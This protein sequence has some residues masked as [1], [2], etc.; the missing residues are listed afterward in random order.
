MWTFFEGCSTD[1]Y[2]RAKSHGKLAS[3]VKSKSMTSR[4]SHRKSIF[5][6]GKFFP[7]YPA[8]LRY[9]TP[10]LPI[11]SNAIYEVSNRSSKLIHKVLME[12]GDSSY[13]LSARSQECSSEVKG[14]LLLAKTSTWDNT[15]SSGVEETESVEF[16]WRAAF[17]L[18]YFDSFWGKVDGREEIHGTLDQVRNR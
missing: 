17:S 13:P 11:I 9:H 10:Q 15:N 18:C 8:P 3:A 1:K 12:L 16:V 6:R 5:K 14:V 4:V 2:F 7:F